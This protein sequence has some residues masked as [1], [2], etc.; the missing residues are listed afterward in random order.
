MKRQQ[1]I[2]MLNAWHEECIKAAKALPAPFHAIVE[3]QERTYTEGTTYKYE[4]SIWNEEERTSATEYRGD[5]I[6][7]FRT[8]KTN[9]NIF[10]DALAAFKADVERIV[11]ENKKQSAA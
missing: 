4:A 8:D 10:N 7:Y 9:I 11:N 6:Y 2:K 1:A 5:C 3:E